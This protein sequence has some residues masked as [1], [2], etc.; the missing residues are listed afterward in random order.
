MRPVLLNLPVDHVLVALEAVH[1]P[2]SKSHCSVFRPDVMKALSSPTLRIFGG[3]VK[4]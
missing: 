4:N 3:R 1:E 2:V